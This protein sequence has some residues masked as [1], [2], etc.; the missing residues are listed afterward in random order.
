MGRLIPFIVFWVIAAAAGC[1]SNE[2]YQRL[3]SETEIDAY[4]AYA[5]AWVGLEVKPQCIM[6]VDA[7]GREAPIGIYETGRR[8]ADTVLVF[9]HGVFADHTSWRFV[10]GEL[11]GEY[12]L[13]LVDLLGCGAAA[14]D[15]DEAWY[16]APDVFGLDAVADRVLQAVESTLAGPESSQ[17]ITLVAHSMGGAITLRM[18]ASDQLR[19]RHGRLLDRVDGLFLIAPLDIAIEKADPTL[20]RVATI[21]GLEVAIGDLTGELREIIAETVGDSV[22]PSGSALREEADKRLEILRDARKRR[23][24]QALLRCAVPSK[25]PDRL[26][27]D[28]DWIRRRT[29]ETQKIQ[30]RTLIVWGEQDETLPASMG[31]KLDAILPNS[32]LIVL[33]GVKHSPQLE[34]PAQISDMV[35]RFVR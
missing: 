8:D 30:E 19:T 16:D 21:T 9:L 5:S 26:K 3:R 10:A 12:R 15:F 11:S 24:T 31:Y 25:R 18:F 33:E 20:A 17:R 29:E 27:P 1:S 7:R 28:W 34:Q 4:Q 14:A 32:E 22:G 2:H 23:A 6:T 35:R 13:V